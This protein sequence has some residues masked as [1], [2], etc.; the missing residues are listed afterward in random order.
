VGVS[1]VD[2]VDADVVEIVG[3]DVDVGEDV[4]AVVAEGRRKRNGFP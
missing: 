2:L 3:V 4:G 1:E